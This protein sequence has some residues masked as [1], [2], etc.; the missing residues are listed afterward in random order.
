MLSRQNESIEKKAMARGYLYLIQLL[1]DPDQAMNPAGTLDEM[2]TL[3][4]QGCTSP[5]MYVQAL[6]I[7]EE[8]V[9]LLRRLDEF[10]MQ[11]MSFGSRR[12]LI[13]EELA[14]R[15]AQLSVT[16]RPHRVLHYRMLRA[17]YE[18]YENKELLSALCGV[19]I[20]SDCRDKRYFSWYQRA[21]NLY[22]LYSFS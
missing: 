21:L 18:K 19:L 8:D 15:I 12:G 5:W 20:R 17:L 10:E 2:H 4:A 1:I 3:F 6:K 13:S 14:K 7:F 16:V 9:K 11:V 22:S